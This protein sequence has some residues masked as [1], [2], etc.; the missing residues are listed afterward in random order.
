MKR[1]VFCLT[2]LFVI[3]LFATTFSSCDPISIADDVDVPEV[4]PKLV[5]HALLCPQASFQRIYVQTTLPVNAELDEYYRSLKGELDAT[6]LARVGIITKAKV[7]IINLSTQ[8]E[9]IP[10]YLPKEYSYVF[11]TK[12]FPL[13]EGSRYRVEVSFGSYPAL[14]EE[15]EIAVH[16]PMPVIDFDSDH[17]SAFIRLHVDRT[18][19]RYFCLYAYSHSEYAPTMP[20]QKWYYLSSETSLDGVVTVRQRLNRNNP[21]EGELRMPQ[22][23]SVRLYEIDESTYRFFQALEKNEEVRDN[24]FSSPSILSNYVRGGFGLVTSLWYHGSVH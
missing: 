18:P 17:F 19:N 22:L 11:D 8:T 15:T 5:L 21:F 10:T 14:A 4:A 12:D 13:N 9:I 24:P 20:L 6:D 1:T 3:L 16:N 23:D 7:R 2:R